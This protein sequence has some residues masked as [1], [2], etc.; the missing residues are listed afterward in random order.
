MYYDWQPALSSRPRAQS[1]H[2]QLGDDE[3]RPRPPAAGDPPARPR[4]LTRPA[5][6]R[7]SQQN[8]FCAVQAPRAS[9]AG[10]LLCRDLRRRGF[11]VRRAKFARAA[12]VLLGRCSRCLPRTRAFFA[13]VIFVRSRRPRARFCENK[14]I[15]AK[16]V[17]CHTIFMLL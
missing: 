3:D 6:R 2:S 1:H 5:S 7:L 11:C 17:R 16:N 15:S 13:A 10:L 9:R 12:V 14:K 8:T 4:R